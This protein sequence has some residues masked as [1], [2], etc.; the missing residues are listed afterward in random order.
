[1]VFVGFRLSQTYYWRLLG[2]ILASQNQSLGCFSTILFFC[3]GRE[4]SLILHSLLPC[5]FLTISACGS[6]IILSFQLFFFFFFFF[7]L[8][9]D[10][11]SCKLLLQVINVYSVSGHNLLILLLF[12]FMAGLRFLVIQL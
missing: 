9:D 7:L 12:R 2:F 1:M 10:F 11:R 4:N 8:S 6:H 5:L 3:L